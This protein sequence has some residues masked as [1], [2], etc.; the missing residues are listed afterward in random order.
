VLIGSGSL[1]GFATDAGAQRSSSMTTKVFMAQKVREESY[2]SFL[3]FSGFCTALEIILLGD[4]DAAWVRLQPRTKC[5]SAIFQ[6]TAKMSLM[7]L[8]RCAV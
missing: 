6:G 7:S 5:T 1:S 2:M 8:F 4:C 3:M